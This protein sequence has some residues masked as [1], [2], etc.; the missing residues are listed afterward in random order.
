[1]V[2]EMM[3][4]THIFEY[5]YQRARVGESNGIQFIVHTAENGH[6][7]PHLHARYRNKEVVLEIPTGAVLA[8]NLESKK[9]GQAS[10]WVRANAS[11][12]EKKWDELA[13]GVYCF[14]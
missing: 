9:M 7:K 14:G 2:P 6:N 12:L 11:F 3:G 8:G 4:W 10:K 1:M 13:K 5:V